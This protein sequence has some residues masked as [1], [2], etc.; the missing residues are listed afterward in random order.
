MS[1]AVAPPPPATSWRS[2]VRRWSPTG[3]GA[4]LTLVLVLGLACTG[5]AAHIAG[6]DS[7]P[8]PQIRLNP[9]AHATGVGTIDLVGLPLDALS[10]VRGAT[11]TADE[12][13]E[14]L[15][16]S[17]AGPDED[18][19]N[20]PPVLGTYSVSHDAIRFS[21][22]FD[23]DPGRSYRVV[24]APSRLPARLD[25]V[26]G[27]WRLRSID[28]TIGEPALDLRPATT[29]V[30][31]YPTSDV[32]PEN[33]LRLYVYFSA[34]MGLKGGAEF[35]HLLDGNGDPVKDPF[36]PLD[37][38]LWNEDRTRYTLLF[39]PGRVK[40][41]I[42]PNE[43]MGR[44]ITAGVTYTLVVDREWRDGSGLPLVEPFTRRFTVGPPDDRAIDPA[45]WQVAPPVAGTNDPIVVSLLRPL[46]YA[47]LRRAIFVATA[48]GDLVDGD[49]DIG[50][51]ETQW[52]FTPREPWGTREYRL[53]VLP[54]LE[55]P[56]GNRVGR[57]F[58]LPSS[59]VAGRQAPSRSVEPERKS[60][61][62]GASVPFL[63]RP[64]R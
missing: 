59:E 9:Q 4:A 17:V 15:R 22:L 60:R 6:G 38:A 12:W 7:L 13:T 5:P 32:V 24:F 1:K 27:A 36:L 37:V 48:R 53:V 3:S 45:E 57:P 52:S 10:A 20:L 23:F 58:E 56:A 44:P 64:E 35:V 21:P 2:D 18:V 33:L 28:V 41:G 31:V 39:D 25:G 34:P 8:I 51:A 40:R 63:P 29:V 50:A 11:L 19:W 47:L 42:L 46:D 61:A 26:S 43:R 49:T 14:W 55:D 16:V 62:S 30:E 54:I